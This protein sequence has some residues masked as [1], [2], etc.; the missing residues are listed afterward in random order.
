MALIQDALRASPDAARLWS[1]VSEEIQSSNT[2]GNDKMGVALSDTGK[3]LQF[4][5]GAPEYAIAPHARS[6]VSAK[7]FGTVNRDIA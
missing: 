5:M 2:L 3:Y 1:Q 6:P 7:S 4:F